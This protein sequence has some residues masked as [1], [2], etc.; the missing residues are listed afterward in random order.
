[1]GPPR[2]PSPTPLRWASPARGSRRAPSRSG[3]ARSSIAREAHGRPAC[4]VPRA[5]RRFARSPSCA[6]EHHDRPVVHRVVHRRAREH[7][8]VEQRHRHADP[9]ARRER[10][11][12]PARRGAVQEQPLV[13]PRE[14]HGDDERLAGLDEPDRADQRLVEDRVGERAVVRS[15]RGGLRIVVLGV[16]LNVVLGSW[17]IC[18]HSGSAEHPVL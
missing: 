12:H 11:E 5:S 3:L 9:H 2:E 7:E 18:S 15:A 10:A 17:P 13:Q 4:R 1:M 6:P 8:T 16:G 14:R